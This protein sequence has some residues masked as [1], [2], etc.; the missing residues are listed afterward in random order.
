ML[1]SEEFVFWIYES[2]KLIENRNLNLRSLQTHPEKTP[3]LSANL[4]EVDFVWQTFRRSG[5]N[6]SAR[7]LAK[8]F[9]KLVKSW[10]SSLET[11]GRDFWQPARNRRMS[12]GE[13]RQE[14]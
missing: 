13:V 6:K 11:A 2:G 12:L 1:N 7:R 9:V 4:W 8:K 14:L 10:E 5:V 3:S